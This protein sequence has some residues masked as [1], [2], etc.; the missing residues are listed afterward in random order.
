M[1][2]KLALSC[3]HCSGHKIVR[4]GH[5][6]RDKLQFF[7]HS[8]SRYFSEDAAKG[9]PHTNIPYP[10]ISYLLYFRKKVPAFSNMRLFRRFV[11]Q[12]L[13]CLG[14]KKGEVSRQ[15]I[16]HWIKNF[17]PDLEDIISFDEARDF[18]HGI[19]SDSLRGVPED[20]IRAKSHP[21]K[22]ALS[23]LEHFLG[24]GFCVD[25]VRSDPVFFNELV[26][27]VS[28]QEL[29]CHRLVVE[30]ER[31]GRPIRDLFFTGVVQ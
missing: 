17:E 19:L 26:D 6:H 22:L 2:K 20:V 16:H 27:I 25:L 18:V 9:Y 11:S 21:Y 8:C 24:R 3:P 30:S 14:V 4:N 10:I 5:P 13:N 31:F 7:C 12:W 28:K 1:G 15:I 23:F 29:Y